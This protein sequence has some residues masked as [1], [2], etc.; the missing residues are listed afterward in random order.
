M[1]RLTEKQHNSDT[2]GHLP[3]N[4]EQPPFE[5]D[6]QSVAQIRQIYA[7]ASSF[8][9]MQDF[10]HEF[11]KAPD[12]RAYDIVTIDEPIERIIIERTDGA[13]IFLSYSD[14][15]SAKMFLGDYRNSTA[16]MGGSVTQHVE[17]EI[18]PPKRAEMLL[19]FGLPKR[20]RK[21]MI[22][23]MEEEYLTIILTK[24]G[25]RVAARWYLW[26]AVRSVLVAMGGRF[27]LWLSV[28]GL[29]KAAGWIVEKSGL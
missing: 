3:D 2:S 21:C 25:A 15:A 23:D 16:H 12:A 20:D 26:Q 7:N 19:H 6:E 13:E 18:E 14:I 29:Y 11:V 10:I 1:S 8:T 28:G 27:R 22:C 9:D 24:Y 5:L 17:S 4:A